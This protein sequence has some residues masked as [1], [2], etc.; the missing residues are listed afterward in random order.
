MILSLLYDTHKAKQSN[1]AEVYYYC[2]IYI[3]VRYRMAE[4]EKGE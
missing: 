2:I 4:K 3:I 1:T